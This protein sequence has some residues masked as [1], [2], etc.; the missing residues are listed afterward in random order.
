MISTIGKTSGGRSWRTF[1]GTFSGIADSHLFIRR[2]LGNVSV[3]RTERQSTDGG[4]D[5]P[6]KETGA[7]IGLPTGVG[8]MVAARK[9]RETV[10][11]L[12]SGRWVGSFTMGKFERVIWIVLD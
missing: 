10:A 4:H 12:E 2:D 7:I 11:V 1:S 5:T 3:I 8:L 9:R 6:G